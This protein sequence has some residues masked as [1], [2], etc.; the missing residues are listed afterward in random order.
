[1]SQNVNFTP[2]LALL[3]DLEEDIWGRLVPLVLRYLLRPLD[4]AS[5]NV[6]RDAGTINGSLKQPRMA[7]G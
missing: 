1:M 7:R 6:S 2:A 4:E 5:E 3:V